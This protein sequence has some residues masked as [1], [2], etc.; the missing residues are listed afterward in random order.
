MEGKLVE[1]TDFVVCNICGRHLRAISNSHLLLHGLTVS[2]YKKKYP[3]SLLCCTTT[4][5]QRALSLKSSYK[6][7]RPVVRLF[8]KANPMQNKQVRAKHKQNVQRKDRPKWVENNGRKLRERGARG[9][10][11]GGNSKQ[12]RII[13]AQKIKALWGDK[14]SIYNS[15]EYLLKTYLSDGWG[16]RKKYLSSFG[17]FFGTK[18]EL[19]F[20]EYLFAKGIAFEYQKMFKGEGYRCIAD[21]WLTKSKTVVEILGCYGAHVKRFKNKELRDNE[22]CRIYEKAGYKWLTVFPE[23]FRNLDQVFTEEE[24]SISLSEVYRSL[25]GEGSEMGIPAVFLRLSGCN[26]RCRGCDTKFAYNTEYRAS[27]RRVLQLVKEAQT[28]YDCH[29]VENVMT[30]FLTGGEVTIQKNLFPLVAMLKRHKFKVIVQTNGTK[31]VKDA[32][33]LCD[34]VSTDYK[35]PCFGGGSHFEVVKKILST[36]TPKS[37]IKFTIATERDI[38]FAKSILNRLAK[39]INSTKIHVVFQPYNKSLTREEEIKNYK[40]MSNTLFNKLDK[41]NRFSIKLLPRLHILEWGNK[42]KK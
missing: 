1:D 40:W 2:E 12:G 32:F 14:T 38:V 27:L 35:L 34:F 31:F 39:Y 16:G 41:L 33:D 22:K 36:Y 9:E 13:V 21:F 24:T 8:G 42:R 4:S 29:I 7:G 26:L 20:G 23:D 6:R 5:K 18:G 11:W 17:R 28:I 19:L 25:C 3:D 37:Q 30:V 10:R 15:D